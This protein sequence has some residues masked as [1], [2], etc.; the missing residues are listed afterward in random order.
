MPHLP[1]LNTGFGNHFS[2]FSRDNS[3]SRSGHKPDIISSLKPIEEET[4]P[5]Y[6]PHAFYP[7]KYGETLHDRY[8]I[9]AKLGYGVTATVW[10][11]K[12]LNAYGESYIAGIPFLTPPKI[13]QR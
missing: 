8:Q 9:V 11:A 7:A 4:N 6:N 1:S 13:S 5:K 10:I 2:S 3:P 12:D